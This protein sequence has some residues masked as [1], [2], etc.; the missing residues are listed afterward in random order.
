[1][2]SPAKARAIPRRRSKVRSARAYGRYAEQLPLNT[3]P[4]VFVIYRTSS[5]GAQRPVSR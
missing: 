2:K 5:L 3:N 4:L 1:M